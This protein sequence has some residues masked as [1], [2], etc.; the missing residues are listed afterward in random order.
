MRELADSTRA[1]KTTTRSSDNR[2]GDV[3]RLAQHSAAVRQVSSGIT[4]PRRA[5][6]R[7]GGVDVGK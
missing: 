2:R 6:H 7:D 5:S 3:G 4:E 1:T